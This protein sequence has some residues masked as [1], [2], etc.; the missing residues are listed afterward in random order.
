ML[1]DSTTLLYQISRHLTALSFMYL[2]LFKALEVSVFIYNEE[3]GINEQIETLEWNNIKVLKPNMEKML[4]AMYDETD[5]IDEEVKCRP[6][7][8]LKPG[9]GCDGVDNDCDGPPDYMRDECDED[10]YPPQIDLSR[11]AEFCGADKHVFGSAAQARDCVETHVS[12]VDDCEEVIQNVSLPVLSESND[13]S[14]CGTMYEVAIS[15][16]EVICGKRTDDTFFVLVDDAIPSNQSVCEFSKGPNEQPFLDMT[17]S[18]DLCGGSKIFSSIADAEECVLYYSNGSDD[19][20]TVDL[21]VSSKKVNTC[22][23]EVTVSRL[24]KCYYPEYLLGLY[25]IHK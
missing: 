3:V 4:E 1:F 16:S 8:K 24:C 14:I 9:H 12:A 15:A 21:S 19:C 7:D 20:R 6:V 25:F 5:Y 11:V 17:K 18:Y 22:E 10:A 2:S 13:L 23:Y